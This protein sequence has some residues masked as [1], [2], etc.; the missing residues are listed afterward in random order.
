[1]QIALTL[2]ALFSA[3]HGLKANAWQAR[4]DKALLSVDLGPRERARLLRKAVADPKA[5]DDLKSA[6]EVLREKGMGKGHPEAIELL[7][8][9]GTTARADLEGL[10]ALRKQVPEVLAD[11]QKSPPS[12][13]SL[14]VEAP[15]PPYPSTVLSSLT[16]L[17]TDSKKQAEL[18][19]EAKDL[20]RS[21]P[22]GLETPKYRVV[23]TLDGPLFL[24]QPE[25][26]ELRQY[27]PYTVARTRMDT[28]GFGSQ[29]GAT[30]FNTL[31][32]YL[33]GNNE[34]R[35]EMSM[36]MPVEVSSVQGTAETSPLTVRPSFPPS[37]SRSC[38]YSTAGLGGGGRGR[39]HGLRPSS[40]VC[41]PAV[42][43]DYP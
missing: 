7:W 22:K 41:G 4:L 16:A 9:R 14:N 32:G 24:G 31:A 2:I 13:N 23:R 33:F 1:M 39:R 8:P 30:G 21:T 40:S 34:Q 15:K 29:A 19:E 37:H 6:I 35:V 25:P 42:R 5:R 10:T 38:L 11:L 17:A 36:T 28:F 43:T 20:L 26:I 3:A 18:R 12:F 27:E